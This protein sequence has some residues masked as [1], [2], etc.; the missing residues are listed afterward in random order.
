VGLA[1]RNAETA[2]AMS[3]PLLFPLTFASSAFVP[4]QSMPGWLQAFAAH[5]PVSVVIDAT[6]A[7]MTGGPTAGP[8]ASALAWSIGLLA[9][10]APLAV[11]RYRKTA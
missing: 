8:V 11:R 5:Q 1:A 7:L 3:F 6:R 2:Q 4:V 9:V 10:F